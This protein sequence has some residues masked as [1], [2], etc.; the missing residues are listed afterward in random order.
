MRYFGVNIAWQCSCEL[1]TRLDVGLCMTANCDSQLVS[2]TQMLIFNDDCPHH[3]LHST[4]LSRIS[5]ALAG[6]GKGE[7]EVAGD[8]TLSEGESRVA[9]VAGS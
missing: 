7:G 5:S 2:L 3:Q 9:I 6:K 1:V 4:N 8:H